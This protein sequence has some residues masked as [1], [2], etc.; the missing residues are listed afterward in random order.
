MLLPED[1]HWTS[2]WTAAMRCRNYPA[3]WAVS[4]ELVA[5][6]DPR[7]RDD[8]RLPYHRRWV[9]DGHGFSGEAVLVRCY[10]GLGDTIQFARFLPALAA[11]AS[12]VTVEVQRPLLPLLSASGIAARFVAFRPSRP[13]RPLPRNVEIMELSHALR[14]PPQAQQP[15]FLRVPEN[16]PAPPRAR[17]ETR[18]PLAALCWRAGDWDVERSLPLSALLSCFSPHWRLATLQR[19]ARE[20]EI[21][22]VP[23]VNRHDPLTSILYTAALIARADLVVSVDTMVAHLA[24]ALG[25]PGFL[26]LKHEA[27]WRWESGNRS[28]WYPSLRLC[29]QSRPGDWHGALTALAAALK[30]WPAD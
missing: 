22:G 24:G 29:R 27:D 17:G 18:E 30:A 28:A 19:G 1:S 5:A 21:A 14:L 12:E 23:F 15:P 26:L 10:H 2:R 20:D 8:P 25:R 4:D 13:R 11:I 6:R 3:A 9:W 7:Q 16:C